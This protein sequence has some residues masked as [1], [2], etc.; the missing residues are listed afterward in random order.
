MKGYLIANIEVRDAA[1]FDRYRQQVPAVI[2]RFGGRYLVRG[3]EVRALEGDLGL[4]RVVILEFP[5][6]EAARRFYES[7]DYE[8]LLELRAASTRSSVALVAGYEPPATSAG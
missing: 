5:S 3:G 1:G 7:P 2:A 4:K 8:P 6:V